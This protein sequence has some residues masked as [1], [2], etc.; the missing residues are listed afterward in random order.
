[1]SII[2]AI[3]GAATVISLVKDAVAA[4]PTVIKT[5]KDMLELGK[6]FWTTLT[7]KEPTAEEAA[8]LSRRVDLLHAEVQAL[9]D[10]D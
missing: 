5:A 3:G 4:A 10:H 2:A 8:D 1:M 9:P 7:G 6:A